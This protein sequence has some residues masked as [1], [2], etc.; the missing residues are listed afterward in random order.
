MSGLLY[1]D[2]VA[3][4]A[5]AAVEIA[6]ILTLLFMALVFWPGDNEVKLLVA[7]LVPMYGLLLPFLVLFVVVS[8]IMGTD[9]FRKKT[10][11]LSLP[12]EKKTYIGAKYIA[13]LVAY[14][15]V[16]SIIV[17]WSYLAEIAFESTITGGVAIVEGSFS[18]MSFAGLVPY[19]VQICLGVSA[20]EIPFFVKFGAK[21]GRAVKQNLMIILFFAMLVFL[22]FG[23]L[24]ILDKLDLGALVEWFEK[25]SDLMLVINVFLTIIVLGLFF[26]SYKISVFLMERKEEADEE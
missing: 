11:L 20:I 17:F 23:D 26:I 25:H 5:K 10:F 13:V 18:P 16:L 24:T 14:Y 12:V 8:S 1:K 21:G 22:L 19:L 2:F 4:K 7:V 3:T 6:A 9:D 15:A